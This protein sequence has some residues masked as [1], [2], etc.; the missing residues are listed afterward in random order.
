FG[1]R[2]SY[3]GSDLISCGFSW[4]YLYQ[5]LLLRS[6]SHNFA[7][8]HRTSYYSLESGLTFEIAKCG[9]S[10]PTHNFSLVYSHSGLLGCVAGLHVEVIC[11]LETLLPCGFV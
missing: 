9:E 3:S 10:L 2:L 6:Y 1:F 4:S 5:F 7:R 8:F 11:G